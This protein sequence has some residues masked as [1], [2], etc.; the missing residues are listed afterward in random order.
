ML[1]ISSKYIEQ[2][3]DIH[4]YMLCVYGISMFQYQ[5]AILNSLNLLCKN[6]KVNTV[7]DFGYLYMI[8][9]FSM[10]WLK[11][12]HLFMTRLYKVDKNKAKFIMKKIKTF[13]NKNTDANIHEQYQQNII[14]TLENNTSSNL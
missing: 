4:Y 13:I 14:F 9:I 11:V 8:M 7:Y 10:Y 6:K 1:S 12:F 3:Y 2:Q 5:C